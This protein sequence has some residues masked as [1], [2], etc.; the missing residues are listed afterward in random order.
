MLEGKK[1]SVGH[2]L[3]VSAAGGGGVSLRKQALLN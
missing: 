3:G 1:I 2:V